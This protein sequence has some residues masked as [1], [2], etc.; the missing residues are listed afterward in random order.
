MTK[1]WYNNLLQSG[2][3]LEHCDTDEGISSDTESP[4]SAQGLI[5]QIHEKEQQILQLKSEVLKVSIFLQ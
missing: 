3:I 5:Q 4:S 2:V 1:L